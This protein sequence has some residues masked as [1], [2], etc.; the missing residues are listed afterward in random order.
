MALYSH[1]PCRTLALYPWEGSHCNTSNERCKAQR[2]QVELAHHNMVTPPTRDLQQHSTAQHKTTEQNTAHS[3]TQRSAAQNST[4]QH[5][6][7]QSSSTTQH[8]TAQQSTTQHS[9][10]QHSTA[11]HDTAQHNTA[12][13]STAEHNRAQHS[14]AR[15]QHSTA[16]HSTAQHSTAQHST[17]QHSTA[18]H[19][20]AQCSTAQHSTQ[21]STR[22]PGPSPGPTTPRK[23]STSA[24]TVP[25]RG[26]QAPAEQRCP[27]R[28][29]QWATPTMVLSTG[30]R[31]TPLADDSFRSS[32]GSLVPSPS[33][34]LGESDLPRH[35]QPR[36]QAA[37]RGGRVTS[38]PFASTR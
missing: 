1:R 24:D 32:R 13:H 37:G 36:L 38:G 3:T 19:S 2:L 14:T 34:P 21:G 12:Q 26:A 35:S 27:H 31:P 6:I 9:T 4:A 28:H 20:A 25:V 11:Q 18:Q 5:S 29:P 16:Q 33:P 15:A 30:G 23:A 10:A 8:S 22:G 17:A 7:A